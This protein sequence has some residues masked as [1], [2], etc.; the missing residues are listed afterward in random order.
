MLRSMRPTALLLPILTALLLCAARPAAAQNE[1]SLL[2]RL[3]ASYDAALLV[4]DLAALDTGLAA[5]ESGAGLGLGELQDAVGRFKRELGMVHGLD[6][7]GP[8]AIVIIEGG[9]RPIAVMLLPVADFD[10]LATSL[11]SAPAD[12]VDVTLPSGESGVL[13]AM[14]GYAVLGANRQVVQ[15]YTAAHDAD[16]LDARIGEH[17][18]QT[19]AQSQVSLI[20]NTGVMDA[21]DAAAQM[22]Y[23][24]T[25]ALRY[26]DDVLAVDL[27]PTQFLP[28]IT[29]ISTLLANGTEAVVAG[30]DFSA[31]GMQYT[32]A[33]KLN[34]H[35]G[36][37]SLFP[38][39]GTDAEAGPDPAHTLAKLL[40]D[41]VVF[42]LAGDPSRV[43]LADWADRLGGLFGLDARHALG[44]AKPQFQELF[45]QAD[46][47]ATA[48]YALTNTADLSS[49]WMNTVTVFEVAD[50]DLFAESL[51]AAVLS[52]NDAE[53][54][55]GGDESITFTTTYEDED[56]LLG[57]VRFDTFTFKAHIPESLR[58]SPMMLVAAALGEVGFT[59]QAAVIDGH[60]LVTTFDDLST[61]TRALETLESANG[62]GTAGPLHNLRTGHLPA[63]PA[64]LGTLNLNGV[65]NTMSPI[66]SA[67]A[68]TQPIQ[69]DAGTQPIGIA[70]TTADG[71]AVVQLFVPASAVTAMLEHDFEP[72]FQDNNANNGG[73]NT[74]PG[75]P[76]QLGPGRQTQPGRPSN[77][78]TRPGRDPGRPGLEPGRNPGRGP[79]RSP[80]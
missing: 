60:V 36:M 52:L 46:G 28:L 62:L 26:A 42:A 13:R 38:G 63:N 34:D 57:G 64:L 50:E 17:A 32:E 56:R 9:D 10:T 74:N 58:T 79:G 65:A 25:L 27:E 78:G 21:G 75:G 15:A 72:H 47:V 51:E 40:D 59:G 37:L 67:V 66:F 6:A 29:N 11:G 44:T 80:R 31:L 76:G 35:A 48:Y 77:P 5:F 7:S 12:I 24:A 8:F 41:P 70:I 22:T 33:Y 49:R 18:A 43:G 71:E 16:A 61:M 19:A 23:F 30:I 4:P 3:P 69:L 54:P 2:D 73:R 1:V 53:V 14:E 45:A 20:V 68:N 39:S 55:V